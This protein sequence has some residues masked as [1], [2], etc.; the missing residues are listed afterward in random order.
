MPSTTVCSRLS[1]LENLIYQS[2]NMASGRSDDKALLWAMEV[3]LE[4]HDES[5][6][7]IVPKRLATLI[8]KLA[9]VRL[10]AGSSEG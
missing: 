8:R 1:C 10:R 9:A 4:E 6:F 2:I 5:Y 7:M 3:E